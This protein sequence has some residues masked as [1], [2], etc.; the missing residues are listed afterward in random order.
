MKKIYKEEKKI[1]GDYETSEEIKDLILA[2]NPS[3]VIILNEIGEIE[4]L[5]PE[6]EKI[7]GSNNILGMNILSFEHLKGSTV[8]QSI[9]GAFAGNPSILYGMNYTTYFSKQD[10]V[11]NIYINPVLKKN[12]KVEKVIIHVYDITRELNLNK[13]MESTYLST[14]EALAKLVDAKDSYTGEHSSNVTR[15]VSLLCECAGLDKEQRKEIEIAAS[16]H[17]IGKIGIP[18]NILNK[19]DKLT[20]E[21]YAIMKKHS[22]IGADIVGKIHGYESIS[23]II[24]HHHERWDGKGYPTGLKENEIPLGAQ[25]I[26]IADSYDAMTSNRIYR[27]S[28]G[29][30]MAMHILLDEKGRQFNA[31]LVD[32]FLETLE[33][34]KLQEKQIG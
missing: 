16:I 2:N 5:N 14:I 7:L 29:R 31:D 3:A 1:L 32:K 6:F 19:P 20:V 33:A 24:K 15:Y 10:K 17:D 12:R 26:C 11:V 30:E 18:D 9:N 8:Y 23:Q 21:E 25:I 4:Y 27:K 28:L 22:V 13:K 34:E